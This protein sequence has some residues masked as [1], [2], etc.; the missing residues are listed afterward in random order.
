MLITFSGPVALPGVELAAGTYRFELL[1]NT[2][3]AIVSVSSANRMKHYLL[4]LTYPVERPASLPA[5]QVITLGETGRGQA[6]RVEAWF[7]DTDVRGKHFIYR[8]G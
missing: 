6:P 7:P 1:S 3:N 5:G 8:D 4:A 2:D